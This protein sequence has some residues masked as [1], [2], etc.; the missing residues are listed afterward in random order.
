MDK[1]LIKLTNVIINES[2][3]FNGSFMNVYTCRGKV[4]IMPNA[5]ADLS[6]S[7]TSQIKYSFE[8][9]GVVGMLAMMFK[10]NEVTIDATQ[11]R[12]H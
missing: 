9:L 1:I 6:L 7:S 5:N 2:V 3:D 10:K 4:S 11:R 8:L 12:Y